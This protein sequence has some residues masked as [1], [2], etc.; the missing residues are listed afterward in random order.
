M[1]TVT[2][3]PAGTHTLQVREEMLTG[4]RCKDLA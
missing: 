2:E 4:L 1:F 3:I